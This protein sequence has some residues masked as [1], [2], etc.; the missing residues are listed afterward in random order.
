M[1]E[2]DYQELARELISYMVF[3][4]PPVPEPGQLTRG[5][6]GILMFLHHHQNGISSGELSQALDLS[7]GRI[8][9]AL[10][11]LEKKGFIQRR[12]DS[13]D[14]RRVSVCI[15]EEG[16]QFILAQEE[17]VMKK[18]EDVLRHLGEEDAPEFVRIMKRIMEMKG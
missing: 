2:L 4:K 6:M 16:T 1:N 8:A 17:K 15:E 3:K 7:T 14:K 18:V 10:K 13:D 5:E 11:G 12:T 9:T